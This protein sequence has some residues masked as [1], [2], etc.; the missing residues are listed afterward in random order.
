MKFIK[1]NLGQLRKNV[2]FLYNNV[3]LLLIINSS[4]YRFFF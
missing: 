4:I 2:R 3:L 1:N